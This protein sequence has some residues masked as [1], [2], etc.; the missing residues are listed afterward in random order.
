VKSKT[1][2]CMAFFLVA[3]VGALNAQPKPSGKVQDA[4][5]M[6]SKSL[7]ECTEGIVPCGYPL[8]GTSSNSWLSSVFYGA[9]YKLHKG[10]LQP[11]L[12]YIVDYIFRIDLNLLET[13]FSINE[14]HLHTPNVA[15]SLEWKGF[16]INFLSDDRL[17]FIKHRQAIYILVFKTSGIDDSRLWIPYVVREKT[18]KDI[19]RL[20]LMESSG[21]HSLIIDES[22]RNCP[23]TRSGMEEGIPMSILAKETILKP[24][25]CNITYYMSVSDKALKIRTFSSRG[26]THLPIGKRSVLS[27]INDEG[28]VFSG[29]SPYFKSVVVS[30]E[31][32][33]S[34]EF[35]ATLHPTEDKG[36]VLPPFF[37]GFKGDKLYLI[38]LD[39]RH[40]YILL[41]K[42]RLLFTSE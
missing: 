17:L 37:L 42:G 20:G 7:A 11:H 5:I 14:A 25:D 9:D 35:K 33:D 18:G 19:L 21:Y 24:D 28:Y 41:D 34:S 40:R 30:S 36:F 1:G 4:A 26:K 8:S 27:L 38:P 22:M 2:I 32:G 39:G 15:Y 12:G 23:K 16:D 13:K 29:Y 6:I 3:I 10:Q 31:K